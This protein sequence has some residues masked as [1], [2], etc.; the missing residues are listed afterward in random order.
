MEIQKINS[1]EVL[2]Y[3][4]YQSNME[5]PL[6]TK[7]Q[8]REAEEITL[9]QANPKVI[10]GVFGLKIQQNTI[11]VEGTNLRF[12]SKDLA[13]TLRNC[14]RV[15]LMAAT[16]G[17]EIEQKMRTLEQTD[18]ALSLMVDACATTLIEQVCDMSQEQLKEHYL[19]ENLYLT[20]RF[21]PGY[22]D[23]PL[24]VQPN[25]LNSLMAGRQIGLQASEECL[26]IPRKSVTAFIGLT[27]EKRTTKKKSCDTC[28]QKNCPYKREGSHCDN[29]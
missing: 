1:K 15:I 23:L 25:F 2:R 13:K 28:G 5:L 8:L 7:K 16:L 18:I 6:K 21:S 4:G 10:T 12:E 20:P 19:K 11:T 22:G 9:Q 27:K 24:T 14:N 29:E 3:L 17:L 26:L